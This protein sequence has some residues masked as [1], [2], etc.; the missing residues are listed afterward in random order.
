LFST[1]DDPALHPFPYGG[2]ALPFRKREYT[3][4]VRDPSTD[5]GGEATSFETTHWSLVLAARGTDRRAAFEALIRLYWKP[6]YVYVRRRWHRSNEDAK[7]LT[8]AFFADLLARE[9]IDRANAGQGRFRTYLRA[10]LDGFLA[11]THEAERALK[12]GGGATTASLDFIVADPESL[13]DVASP[14]AV[15]E[16]NW[17]DAVL[18]E[19]VERLR[20][21][22]A[23]DGHETWFAVFESIH[24]KSGDG[25]TYATVAARLGVP[26]TTVTNHLAR[27]RARFRA[28]VRGLVRDSVATEADFRDEMMSIFGEE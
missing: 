4:H 2:A 27:A 9:S 6:V 22:C 14:E 3:R 24:L 8:Q 18:H 25:A 28:L 23:R 16:R 20:A 10:C 12:R 21:E 5:I 1:P 7:D 26:E 13:D 15:Y 17:K 19:A 11:K